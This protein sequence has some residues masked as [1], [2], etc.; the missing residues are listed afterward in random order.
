MFVPF[1]NDRRSH[2]DKPEAANFWNQYIGRMNWLISQ[3]DKLSS[4]SGSW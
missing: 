1:V 4:V 3:P 2:F